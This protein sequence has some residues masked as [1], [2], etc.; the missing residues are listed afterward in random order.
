[1][2]TS[3]ALDQYLAA[4]GLSTEDAWLYI[5]I[6]GLKI[7]YLPR[8]LLPSDWAGDEATSLF[9]D[10]HD[11]LVGPADVYVDSVLDAAPL[12]ASARES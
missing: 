5:L 10:L 3:Q 12:P 7:P 6:G 1:M 8:A 9:H 11:R 2:T 4:K